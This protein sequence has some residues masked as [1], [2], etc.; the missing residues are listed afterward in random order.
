M[1]DSV[2]H[3]IRYAVRGL[4]ASPAFTLTAVL[5]LTLTLGANVGIFSTLNALAFRRLP[6]PNPEELVRLTTRFPTGQEV[7]FSFPMFRELASR[8]RAVAPLMAWWGALVTVESQ[9]GLTP[10]VVTGVTGNFYGELGATPSAGRL[11]LPGDVDLETFTGEPVAVIGYGFWQRRFGGASSAIGD[12]VRVDGVPF[13]IVGV[14]PRGFRGFGLLSEP[15]VT[16]PLATSLGANQ[17]RF[18]QAGLLWLSVAGRIQRG[19]GIEQARARLEA[20]WPAIK[21][22]IIPPTHTGAQR[23]NF[24]RLPLGLE[25]LATGHDSFLTG[26]R[27]PLVALQGLALAT[28]IIGCLNLAGLELRRIAKRATDQAIRMALG[29][30]SWQALRA[31]L[32]EGAL[33]G[34]AGGLCA[35]LLGSWASA[36]ITRMMLPSGPVPVSL[37][38]GIDGRVFAFTAAVTMAAG[39]LC[40][41]LPAWSHSRRDRLGALRDQAQPATVSNRLLKIVLVGQLALSVVL[42]TNAGLLVRSLQRVLSIDL[43]FNSDDVVRA[44]FARRPGVS[45]PP[46]GE[47]YF[48]M[49]LERVEALPNVSAASLSRM[50]PG[51]PGFKWLVS[52][53]AWQPTEGI[54]ATF[55]SVTTGFFELLDV[56][57]IAGRD[58]AWTDHARAPRVAVLSSA[59]ARRLFPDGHVLGQRVRIGTQPYRQDLEVIGIVADARLHDMKDTSSYAAYIPE[60]QNGEPAEGGWLVIRGR[61]DDHLL[62]E[63]VQSVGPDF[64]RSV[65]GIADALGVLVSPDR[66]VALLAG[67][68]GAVALLLAAIGV[69]GLFAYTVLLRR[70]ETAIRLALGA[71][72]WR[73]VRSILNEGLLIAAAG[74][75]AGVGFGLAS[76]GFIR[77]LLFGL[78]PHDPIVLIGV[79][80]VLAA[81]VMSAC[82]LPALRAVRTDPTIGLRV[83]RV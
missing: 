7:P 49:L 38:T 14:A 54:S 73:I 48:P 15:D 83:D 27:K 69:G 2:I 33:I 70:K 8:Q 12:V 64:V 74:I 19:V 51:S 46:A 32:I 26:F 11:L 81:V 30:R 67:F 65:E 71:D 75:T 42:L 9:G 68:F 21:A 61:P 47:S 57:V 58:F 63:A 5:T 13:T 18:V 35:L 62:Q 78:D 16:V 39:V 82:L 40:A 80:A 24:L 44:S 53:M 55:N 43:G 76:T 6:A 34:L 17:G 23:E 22:D 25:S 77:G 1:F 41:W 52:P 60:L 45:E 56:R 29:A 10:A 72:P 66:T 59:L 3:D 50:A 20:V 31:I 28:L 79:P 37:D 36:A 4:C